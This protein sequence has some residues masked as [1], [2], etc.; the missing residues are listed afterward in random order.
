VHT[1]RLELNEGRDIIILREQD[2]QIVVK[3][4]DSVTYTRPN[5]KKVKIFFPEEKDGNHHN[6]DQNVRV[7]RRGVAGKPR[8]YVEPPPVMDVGWRSN[9]CRTTEGQMKEM[10]PQEWNK[11]EVKIK[12]SAQKIKLLSPNKIINQGNV[13]SKKQIVDGRKSIFAQVYELRREVEILRERPLDALITNLGSMQEIIGLKSQL[14]EEILGKHEEEISNIKISLK[15]FIKS[16]ELKKII[17]DHALQSNLQTFGTTFESQ[18][19]HLN[20]FFSRCDRLKKELT[21]T[22][23]I[24]SFFLK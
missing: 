16:E 8:T 20:N 7:W 24:C 9:W 11:D 21:Q 6:G 14:L 5:G 15:D 1:M 13:D 23:K 10:Q 12:N 3:R 18:Q 4:A 22:K 17:T 19:S 2:F